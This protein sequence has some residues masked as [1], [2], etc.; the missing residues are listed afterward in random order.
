[1]R[2]KTITILIFIFFLILPL[3]SFIAGQFLWY[4]L[5]QL[6]NFYMPWKTYIIELIE[7]LYF[8]YICV[9]IVSAIRLLLKCKKSISEMIK[10]EIFGYIFSFITLIIIYNI[11]LINDIKII[12]YNIISLF[13]AACIRIIPLSK[14]EIEN[15]EFRK[16]K[17]PSYNHEEYQHN[18]ESFHRYNS[19]DDFKKDYYSNIYSE[20]DE[21]NKAFHIF[22]MNTDA[23]FEEIKKKRNILIKIFHPDKYANYKDMQKYAEEKTKEINEAFD[24]LKKFYE[25]RNKTV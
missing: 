24:I 25:S 13:I 9:Y 11:F 10:V 6:C 16:K 1:M 22:E 15:N 18:K 12:I 3:V 23:T 4:E 7:L 17:N 19:H 8:L 14:I 21:V 20:Q 5:Y 2:S